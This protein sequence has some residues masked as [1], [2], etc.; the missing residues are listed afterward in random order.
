MIIDN[1]EK[2]DKAIK[3][4]RLYV[5]KIMAENAECI[6]M[7]GKYRKA[8]KTLII[9]NIKWSIHKLEIN[10]SNAEIEKLSLVY[11]DKVWDRLI[12]EWETQN[13][14][15]NVIDR[16]NKMRENNKEIKGIKRIE[17]K[18]IESTPIIKGEMVNKENN[19]NQER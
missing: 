10:G 11:L 6:N 16:V 5:P 14:W 9:A 3:F 15:K 13:K 17:D 12:R 1:E 4:L 2:I 7:G 18:S 8:V 19:S